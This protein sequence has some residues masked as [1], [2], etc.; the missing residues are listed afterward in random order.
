MGHVMQCLSLE[1][2]IIVKYV[3]G[4]GCKRLSERLAKVV[5][6]DIKMQHIKIVV[7]KH[8]AGYLAYPWGVEGVVIG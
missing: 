1:T 3:M 6:K 4:V 7:E 5:S 2:K 8:P